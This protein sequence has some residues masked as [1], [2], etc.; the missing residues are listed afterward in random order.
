MTRTL[1]IQGQTPR[2]FGHLLIVACL[3]A[4]GGCGAAY[5]Y[6]TGDSPWKEY[7]FR[8]GD[9][10]A[11]LPFELKNEPPRASQKDNFAHSERYEGGNEAL[12][13]AVSYMELRPGRGFVF[14]SLFDYSLAAL[15]AR[16][17]M[18]VVGQKYE[19]FKIGRYSA[20]KMAV[21]LISD[22]FEARMEYVYVLTAEDKC[23]CVLNTYP[24]GNGKS[25]EA[26]D[27]VLN[28]IR[29]R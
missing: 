11:S 9:L 26:S 28:S 15:K 24:R 29:L 6:L 23:W 3:L 12:R 13:V 10:I 25:K 19:D 8:N 14:K 1:K 4:V 21:D 2:T 17:D 20:G 27:K 22:G 16:K 5:E 18:R 7:T